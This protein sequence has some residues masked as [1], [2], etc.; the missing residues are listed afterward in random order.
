MD[1]LKAVHYLVHEQNMRC[2]N[3]NRHLVNW[4][5]NEYSLARNTR[6]LVKPEKISNFRNNIQNC[7]MKYK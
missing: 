6:K 3:F 2:V 7:N 1:P 4:K 5:L